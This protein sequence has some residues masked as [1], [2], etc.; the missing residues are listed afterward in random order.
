MTSAELGRA[1]KF[2][3]PPTDS[4]PTVATQAWYRIYGFGLEWILFIYILYLV[5]NEF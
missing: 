4:I 5:C 3:A 1:W 2:Y